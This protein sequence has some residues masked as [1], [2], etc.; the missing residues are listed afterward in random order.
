[1]S[2]EVIMGTSIAFALINGLWQGVLLVASTAAVLR[3]LPRLNAASAG[4]IWS[5]V[6][7]VAAGLPAADFL[8]Q[9]TVERHPIVVPDGPALRDL[10]FRGVAKLIVVS[11][12]TVQQH[13]AA[14]ATRSVVPI[15]LQTEGPLLSLWAVVSLILLLRLARGY[16]ALEGIKDRARLLGF[17]D[18]PGNVRRHVVVAASAEVES[19]C[20]AGLLRP[21]ILLPEADIRELA[22]ADLARVL[23]HERAHLMRRDDYAQLLEQIVRAVFFFH[24]ALWYAQ[25]RIAALRELA[26]DDAAIEGRD[27]TESRA[28]ARTLADMLERS[29]H[30]RRTSYAPAFGLGRV[31]I[32]DRVEHM[33]DDEADRA[34]RLRLS[35]IVFIGAVLAVAVVIAPMQVPHAITIERPTLAV[36]AATPGSALL[37]ALAA[38]G[39]GTPSPDALIALQNN[40]VD[41]GSVV[42]ALGSDG[43][44]SIEALIMLSNNDVPRSFTAEIEAGFPSISANDIVQLHAT[45]ASAATIAALV[46]AT[47]GH[48]AVSSLV[49]LI[50]NGVDADF[51]Q[52]LAEHGYRN[53]PLDKL[54]ALKNSGFEP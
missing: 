2:G 40:D 33:L 12:A 47:G 25:R 4:M 38:N 50:N 45:D 14:D 24:P 51:V 17:A 8:H 36:S 30:A 29:M 49:Q 46:H 37:D 39:Y 34:A 18:L 43:R 7:L 28:Y 13:L 11:P 42:R 31:R 5:V 52:R 21:M 32:T 3:L 10:G 20:A 54:I 48:P 15:A 16:A 9:K 6:F 19:P 1:L 44:P 23:R 41:A 27:A 35:G 26:C 53:L 22:A